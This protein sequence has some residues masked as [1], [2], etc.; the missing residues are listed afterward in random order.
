MSDGLRGGRSES[1]QKD[2]FVLDWD[3]E[4]MLILVVGTEKKGKSRAA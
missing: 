3:D 1:L 4:K 2:R